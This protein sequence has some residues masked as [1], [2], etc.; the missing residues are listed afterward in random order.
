MAPCLLAL[1]IA[2]C[3]GQPEVLTLTV[4]QHRILAEV[5]GTFEARSR[6]LMERP[7]LAPDAGMLLVFPDGTKPCL[8]MRNTR[9]ALSAAFL[10]R[11]GRIVNIVDMAPHT[12]YLHC[13]TATAR[14]ALEVNQ[15]WYSVRGI[16]A[17]AQV[18]GLGGISA[19]SGS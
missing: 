10:D 4:G 3:N 14:Y 18:M 11:K 5:A 7:S 16:D 13:A 1:G 2:G 17:G 6:G 8:W 12:R 19:D 9:I 15:D